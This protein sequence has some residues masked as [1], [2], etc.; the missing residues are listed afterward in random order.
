M[1]KSA[2]ACQYR[3]FVSWQ[4]RKL[5]LLL[6]EADCTG[7]AGYGAAFLTRKRLTS[8]TWRDPRSQ[9]MS[10]WEAKRTSML[11]VTPLTY[12]LEQPSIRSQQMGCGRSLESAG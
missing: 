5:L 1:S 4:S 6:N 9:Q 11:F 3:A 2:S 12:T 8:N 10:L 7:L